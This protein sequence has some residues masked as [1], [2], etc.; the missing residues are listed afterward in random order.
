MCG[1]SWGGGKGGR[2]WERVDVGGGEGMK[3]VCN[4]CRLDQQQTSVSLENE[5]SRV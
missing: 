2:G 4:L 5:I 1:A 3:G